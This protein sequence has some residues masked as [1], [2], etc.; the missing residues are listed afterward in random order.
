MLVSSV[1]CW[2]PPVLCLPSRVRSILRHGAGYTSSMSLMQFIF[3][4]A[5]YGAARESRL[6]NL[7]RHLDPRSIAGKRVLEVGCGTGELGQA[8]VDAG[9]HV[10][11]VD[12]RAE[13]IEE[14]GRRTPGRV[15]Y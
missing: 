5:H 13:Y 7:F 4:N 2:P 6:R 11:S 12:A 14:I 3:D 15:A 1:S 10:V 8:F 9:G